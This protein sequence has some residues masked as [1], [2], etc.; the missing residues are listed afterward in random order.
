VNI[1]WTDSGCILAWMSHAFFGKF[2]GKFVEKVITDHV[3]SF[4]S[5]WYCFLFVISLLVL[6]YLFNL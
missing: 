5:W 3:G 6:N 1:N 4:G 2:H